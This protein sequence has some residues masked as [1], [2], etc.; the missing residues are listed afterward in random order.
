MIVN[1]KSRWSSTREVDILWSSFITRRTS[2]RSVTRLRMSMW[3]PTFV[4]M[5]T[6]RRRGRRSSARMP[7]IGHLFTGWVT[8]DS[9][10]TFFPFSC[11]LRVRSRMV[12]MISASTSSRCRCGKTAQPLISSCE[13]HPVAEA[14]TS[15]AEYSWHLRG[16]GDVDECVERQVTSLSSLCHV[17]SIVSYARLLLHSVLWSCTSNHC[18]I[19]FYI[20]LVRYEQVGNIRVNLFPSY[21]FDEIQFRY[22]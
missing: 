1:W 8:L 17:Q 2:P 5:D 16:E 7:R 6:I 4:G 21:G 19:T 3:R 9:L 14:G 13:V 18:V 11:R 22:W 12:S 20:T 15:E 10:I